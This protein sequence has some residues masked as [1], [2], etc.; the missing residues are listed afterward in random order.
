M[1]SRKVRTP[2]TK[3]E[4][5]SRVRAKDTKPERLVRRLLSERGVRYRLHRNDLPGKP[6]IFVPRLRLAIFVHGC[7]WHGHD[8]GRGAPPKS[9]V[10]FWKQKLTG[11]AAR[12]AEQAAKLREKGIDI[13]VVWECQL[14]SAERECSAIARR[15][16]RRA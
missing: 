10:D 13:K 1:P 14:A 16:K 9:N 6:D 2:L 4:Q 12:D 5:M 11:N 7:F 15:Y 3:S 8:C